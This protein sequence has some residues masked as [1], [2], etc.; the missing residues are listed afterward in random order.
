M[1][2]AGSVPDVDAAVLRVELDAKRAEG[3]SDQQLL[4]HMTAVYQTLVKPAVK[5]PVMAIS[6]SASTIGTE[7]RR[8]SASVRNYA[9]PWAEN[10]KLPGNS[11]P[12]AEITSELASLNDVA[13]PPRPRRRRS[14]VGA[15]PAEEEPS[16]DQLR[17][18]SP[19]PADADQAAAAPEQVDSWES[20]T[21][22]P[23]CLTCGMAFS[24][25]AK[26]ENHVKFSSL[27]AS[28]VADAARGSAAAPA[29]AMAALTVS[30]APGATAAV[31]A[32]ATAAADA[33][34]A[35]PPLL[36]YSGS[37]L[38]WRTSTEVQ[39]FLLHHVSAGIIEVLGFSENAVAMGRLL[40]S[41]SKALALLN[42]E[43]LTSEI[44]R[45]AAYV[46]RQSLQVTDTALE[47]DVRRKALVTAILARIGLSTP[48]AGSSA[49][50]A[51]IE[52]TA[53]DG[54]ELALKAHSSSLTIAADAAAEALVT[55]SPAANG[56]KMPLVT[57]R[58]SVGA[59]DEALAA[60]DAGAADLKR[61]RR[62]S[63]SAGTKLTEAVV[64]VEKA[65]HELA[66]AAAAV[67]AETTATAG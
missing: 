40:A 34:A 10:A 53:L 2:A 22:Q 59:V 14:V 3:Y 6:R 12:A 60:V 18:L 17:P 47:A 54:D 15:K 65:T 26:K 37:K 48:A 5:E 4:A 67:T 39:I 30:E 20:V 31:P 41:H 1:G 50:A 49:A 23:M 9:K 36:I 13:S 55:D 46:R 7:S 25:E 19:S 66:T 56:W 33:T 27:H 61:A 45:M 38:F 63:A 51:A 11:E 43:S 42:E 35:V 29:A 62:A 44:Q 28:R 32:A 52:F 58:S 21:A 24:S 64:G 57:R 16:A 8:G